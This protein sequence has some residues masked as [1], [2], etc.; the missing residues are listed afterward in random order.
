[1]GFQSDKGLVMAVVLGDE[2]EMRPGPMQVMPRLEL[3]VDEMLR[4]E[5]L[6]RAMQLALTCMTDKDSAVRVTNALIV[7][8]ARLFYEFLSGGR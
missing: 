1:M 7:D 8:Q 4:L 5:A 3:T 2:V 6:D